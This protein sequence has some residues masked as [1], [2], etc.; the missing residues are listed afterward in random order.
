MTSLYAHLSEIGV[1]PG[2]AV[3]KGAR[4]GALG[5]TGRCYGDHLHFEIRIHGAPV[6]P[7]LHIPA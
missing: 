1:A 3:T 4:L 6:D 7:L 5:C 2:Q